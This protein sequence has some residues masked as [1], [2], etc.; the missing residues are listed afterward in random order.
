MVRTALIL[1][2]LSLVA[3]AETNSVVQI[4]TD[5]VPSDDFTLVRCDWHDLLSG[6]R[7]HRYHP[8]DA[9]LDYASGARV[10]ELPGLRD[11]TNYETSVSL[12]SAAGERVA[13]N[14]ARWDPIQG[15]IDPHRTIVVTIPVFRPYSPREVS[16]TADLIDDPDGD[17][18]ISMGDRVRYTVNITAGG[19][20]TYEDRVG[21][22]QRLAVGSVTTTHGAVREGNVAGDAGV[23]VELPYLLPDEMATIT[24]DARVEPVV[25]SQGIVR[26]IAPADPQDPDCDGFSTSAVPSDDPTT[27]APG[28]ATVLDVHTSLPEVL[29]ECAAIRQQLDTVRQQLDAAIADPDG[30]GVPAISD[31]CPGTPANTFV[32]REGC[33]QT[34]FC[35]RYAYDR[36]LD[37]AAR[38]LARKTCN[39]AD[40]GNDEPL[41]PRD[42]RPRRGTCIPRAELPPNPPPPLG[43]NPNP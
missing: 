35:A 4:R 43:D 2:T 33:S 36:G 24:F 21:P 25:V 14:A 28:D 22:G 26:T 11:D 8:V 40:W 41:S 3:H 20:S 18:A 12:L 42:C 27:Q 31:R 19:A 9:A 30:D 1:A 29:E 38:K 37:V 17:G 16:K 15:G 34:T 5:Y 10:C 13:M 23:V 7:N 39:R 6:E 32:D